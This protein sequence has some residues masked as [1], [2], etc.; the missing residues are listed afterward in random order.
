MLWALEASPT[1]DVECSPE[2]CVLRV[3]PKGDL[4]R[5][6]ESSGCS[7]RGTLGPSSLLHHKLGPRCTPDQMPCTKKTTDWSGG[8]LDKPFFFLKRSASSV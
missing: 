5:V 4:V 8:A 1:S 2:L 7:F 6:L 3:V